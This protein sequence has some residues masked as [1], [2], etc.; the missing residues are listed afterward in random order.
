MTNR[1]SMWI[2]LAFAILVQAVFVIVYQQV[3]NYLI[4]PKVMRRS[5]R[6]FAR[7]VVT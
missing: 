4:Y 1:R 7:A 2:A 3:E 6:P 5:V